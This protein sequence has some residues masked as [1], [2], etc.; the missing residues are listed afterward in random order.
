MIGTYH[1]VSPQHLKRYL[2][3]FDLRY[4]ERDALGVGDEARADKLV[5]SIVG[6][7]LTYSDSSAVA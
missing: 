5:R 7:R 6:K 1:H 4:S 3:E 2:A